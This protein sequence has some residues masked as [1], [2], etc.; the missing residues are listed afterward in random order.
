[1]ARHLRALGEEAG[2]PVGVVLEGGYALDALAASVAAAVEALGGDEAPEMVAAHYLT[3][4]PASH[5]GHHRT[6]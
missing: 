4:Q 6:L 3:A 1:M 2:A 5:I